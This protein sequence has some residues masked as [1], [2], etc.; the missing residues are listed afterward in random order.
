MGPLALSY[1]FVD[2]ASTAAGPSRVSQNANGIAARVDA[3]PPSSPSVRYLAA[4][5][6][7]GGSAAPRAAPG[8][9]AHCRE[10]EGGGP[11][12]ALRRRLRASRPTRT[13][14]TRRLTPSTSARSTARPRPMRWIVTVAHYD[15]P[16][17]ARRQSPAGADDNASSVALVSA[18]DIRWA[19]HRRRSRAPRIVLLFPA[20]PQKGHRTS[21]RSG[22]VRRGSGSIRRCR[23][24][25]S[26]WRSSSISWAGARRKRFARP[27]WRMRC[28]S[29]APRRRASFLAR[30]CSRAAAPREVRR[31]QS[32]DDRSDAYR[33][34][35]RFARSDYHGLRE[36]GRRPFLFLT[37]GRTETCHG[38][39]HARTADYDRLCALSRWVARLAAHAADVDVE[40]GWQDLRADARTDARR[41]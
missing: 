11:R 7:K 1:E 18:L 41:C 8:A 32:A 39:R 28:S 29:S 20:T 22:W 33:P 30:A 21:A 27:V 24:I 13:V 26:T 37:T 17:R 16:G 6:L 14:P 23:P 3:S 15:H 31:L 38:C 4:P 36:H 9:R 12:A 34:G 40:L 5:E 2:D 35:S 10:L 19:A 25:G